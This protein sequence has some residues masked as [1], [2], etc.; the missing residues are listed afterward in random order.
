MIHFSKNIWCGRKMEDRKRGGWSFSLRPIENHP[1]NL[2]G[3]MVEKILFTYNF[4]SFRFSIISRTQEQNF[5]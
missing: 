3:K 5:L 2:T 1:P 4:L